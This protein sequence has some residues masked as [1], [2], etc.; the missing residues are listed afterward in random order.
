MAL[1]INIKQLEKFDLLYGIFKLMM[2]MDY[3]IM[4]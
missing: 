4:K 1:S 2:G 3:G